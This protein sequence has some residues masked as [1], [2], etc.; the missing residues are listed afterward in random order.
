[1]LRPKYSYRSLDSSNVLF[2]SSERDDAARKRGNGPS[3]KRRVKQV[4]SYSAKQKEASAFMKKNKEI[5]RMRNLLA[6]SGVE[7][8]PDDIVS[9]E[10]RLVS[11]GNSAPSFREYMIEIMGEE[12]YYQW[13]EKIR[14]S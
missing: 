10:E 11:R 7:V 8:L 13:V 4:A 12:A 6:E 1:V 2:E 5:L 9:A 14:S 3:R